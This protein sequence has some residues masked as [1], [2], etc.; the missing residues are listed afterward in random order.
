M[1]QSVLWY[2]TANY[3][4]IKM[5]IQKSKNTKCYTWQTEAFAMPLACFPMK[6]D[7]FVK[8]NLNI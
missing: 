6:T 7:Q 1:E 5:I 8:T 4:D 3:L 2:V